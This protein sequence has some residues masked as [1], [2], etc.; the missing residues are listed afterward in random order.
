MNE[1]FTQHSQSPPVRDA[2]VQA[3]Q[4]R[5]AAA[6]HEVAGRIRSIP[7]VQAVGG[8][9]DLPL[10]HSEDV[11]VMD[12]EGNA[13]KPGRGAHVRHTNGDYF[14]AMQI[15]LIAGRYLNDADIPSDPRTPPRAVVV[16]E[17]LAKLYFP[18][19]NAVGRR[20]RLK[21]EGWSTI[22]GV[23]ADVRHSTLE[24]VPKAIVYCP[25]WLRSTLTIQTALPTSTAISLI[26]KVVAAVNGAAL[27]DVKTM[28]DYVVEANAHRTFQTAILMAFA[29]IALLLALVGLYGLLSYAVRQRTAEV[30]VRMALGAS[31]AAQY[32]R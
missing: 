28:N 15:Q 8:I 26:R 27:T 1:T 17:K 10:S 6:F 25:S 20:L 14:K 30:G 4:N 12:V 24:E 31:R 2:D 7:G 19:S 11:F 32:W 3:Q 21:Q 23:V 9:D 22:V 29:G 5:I 13:P 16:S 18:H